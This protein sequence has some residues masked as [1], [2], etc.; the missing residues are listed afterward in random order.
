MEPN[1]TQYLFLADIGPISDRDSPMPATLLRCKAG[2][3]IAWMAGFYNGSETQKIVHNILEAD[4]IQSNITLYRARRGT[5]LSCVDTTPSRSISAWALPSARRDCL[6]SPWTSSMRVAMAASLEAV[7]C[8]K[9]SSRHS[10]SAAARFWLLTVSAN[11]WIK[12]KKKEKKEVNR[13][14][15][16]ASPSTHY[17][18]WETNSALLC[19]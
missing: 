4:V 12:K 9:L 19:Y 1:I 17:Q 13:R 18:S 3:I 14:A 2:K 6:R 7:S 5:F 11:A 10:P 16:P 8:S 15:Q